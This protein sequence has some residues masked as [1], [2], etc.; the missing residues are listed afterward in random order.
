MSFKPKAKSLRA[1]DS[2]ERMHRFAKQAGPTLRAEDGFGM[3][4][5][6]V[7]MSAQDQ[8][9][10]NS[11]QDTPASS[12]LPDSPATPP[13]APASQTAPSLTP[14]QA[15]AKQNQQGVLQGAMG[16]LRASLWMQDGGELHAAD[17]GVFKTLRGYFGGQKTATDRR[18]A[19][20]EG[21]PQPQPAPQPQPTPDPRVTATNPAG[22]QF[23]TGGDLRTGHGGV[24]PGKG[25]GDKIPAKYEPG[26]FVV[27]NDMLRAK[28]QLRGELRALRKKVLAEKGMTVAQADAKAVTVKGLRALNAGEWDNLTQQQIAKGQDVVDSYSG[29]RSPEARAR[30]AETKAMMT[31]RANPAILDTVAGGSV[32]APYTEGLPPSEPVKTAPPAGRFAKM[33]S[34]LADMGEGLKGRAAQAGIRVMD[35]VQAVANSPA[36]RAAGVVL[37]HPATQF[38]M[39]G[40][41]IGSL[42]AHSEELAPGTLTPE[43]IAALGKPWNPGMKPI[44]VVPGEPNAPTQS[45]DQT[46]A[47]SKRLGLRLNGGDAG[48]G[49]KNPTLDGILDNQELRDPTGFS[50]AQIAA[51]NPG[52]KVTKVVG[53]DGKVSYSGSNVSGEVSFQD[54][55]G[56]ALRGMPGGGYVESHDRPGE[57]EA[58]L[59]SARASLRNPDGSQWSASDNAIMAA[60]LRDGVDPYRGTSRAARSDESG[61][62]QRFDPS[63]Y[64]GLPLPIAQAMMTADAQAASQMAQARLKSST[65]L[66]TTGMNNDSTRQVHSD[67]RASAE[68][69]ARLPFEVKQRQRDN[70][71]AVLNGGAGSKGT[72][73]PVDLVGARD[74]MVRSGRPTD[75]IDK[76]IKADADLAKGVEDLESG[77]AKRM[78][79]MFKGQFANLPKEEAEYAEGLAA[80]TLAKMNSGE[81]VGA[82]KGQD[83]K[84]QAL[85]HTRAIL[86]MQQKQK[87]RNNGWWNTLGGQE[88]RPTSIDGS[89]TPEQA[90]LWGWNGGLRKGHDFVSG[91]YNYGEQ[92]LP[93]DI[94]DDVIKYLQDYN[95]LHTASQKKAK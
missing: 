11:L 12:P 60:N 72:K 51:R 50:N 10:F 66:R 83:M 49:T 48:R 78:T 75:E 29:M 56:K 43:H 32:T 63:K 86:G 35:G 76:K 73:G 23:K 9:A 58:R 31:P 68:R 90:G 37:S 95:Q 24:V 80:Q 53:P 5:N 57:A 2:M 44:S 55:N 22:I 3:P 47:Y 65:D 82:A 14:A 62:A 71:A 33:T 46:D 40:V 74:V 84:Q 85:L 39:K 15:F 89:A 28:P 41:N 1:A 25:K 21:T 67:D 93:A 45:G 18:M 8:G 17:G 94:G 77:K 38:A 59:A 92:E 13:P 30:V 20:A 16:Q 88:S 27:S 6:K 91:D 79:E 52:G 4:M 19:V 7:P 26:E 69:V 42:A 34:G 54:A 81:I 36:A 87:L 70:L 61:G 64:K